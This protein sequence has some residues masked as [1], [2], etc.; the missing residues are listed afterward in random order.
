MPLDAEFSKMVSPRQT[1]FMKNQHKIVD[2]QSL[3]RPDSL[4][5]CKLCMCRTDRLSERRTAIKVAHLLLGLKVKFYFFGL[6][7]SIIRW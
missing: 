6:L 1:N 2:F 4:L 5:S 3:G 7:D